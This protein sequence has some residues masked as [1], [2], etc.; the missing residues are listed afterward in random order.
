MPTSI[1]KRAFII[2]NNK[3]TPHYQIDFF[4]KNMKCLKYSIY[5]K[6]FFI[7]ITPKNEK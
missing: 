4:Y 5:F 3:K 1:E 6:I 2:N 7:D